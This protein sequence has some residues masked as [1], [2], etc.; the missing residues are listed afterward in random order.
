MGNGTLHDSTNSTGFRRPIPKRTLGPAESNQHS[1]Y[2]FPESPMR[3]PP[4]TAVLVGLTAACTH[5]DPFTSGNTALGGP[6]DPTPPVRLTYNAGRDLTPAWG[7]ASGGWAYAFE[8]GTTDRDICL[9]MLP[10][11]GGTRLYEKCDP[12]DPNHQLQDVML[13]PA[14]SPTGRVAWVETHMMPGLYPPVRASLR[15]GSWAATDTGSLVRPLPYFA[16]GGATYATQ[17][18]LTW[19]GRDTLVVVAAGVAYSQPGGCS[20][21]KLDT[22]LLDPEIVLYDLSQTPV[23]EAVLDGTRGATS[24]RASEDRTALLFT[25]EADSRVLLYSLRTGDTLD[26]FDFGTGRRV[27]DASR[28]GNRLW[29][30]VD[31]TPG[32]SGADLGGSVSAV[33]LLTGQESLRLD[34]DRL[35]RHAAVAPSGTPAVVEG[36]VIAT[37]V[38]P[39]S[40]LWLVDQ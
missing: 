35:Y 21:C 18:H 11:S 27:R 32:Q 15:V 10:A 8:A 31:G 30:I 16:P 22:L 5:T 23:T 25:R 40:D 33:D 36:Y 20:F 7:S 13:D 1:T 3:F 6:R 34:P 24:V 39:V 14:E 17:H 19:L 29:A 38:S 28:V 9:G 4:R 2:R 26:L 12:R 37:P